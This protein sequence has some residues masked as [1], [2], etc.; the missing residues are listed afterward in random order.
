MI[1]TTFYEKIVELDPA[2]HR[3][4]RFDATHCNFEFS[5]HYTAVPLSCAEFARAA[6]EYPVVF[7]RDKDYL[8]QPVVLLGVKEAENLY[9]NAAGL[10]E[11]TYLPVFVG[12]YPFVME[13][14]ADSSV[15]RIDEKCV[16]LNY[17][18]GELLVDDEGVIQPRLQDEVKF[19]LDYRQA[20]AD[21]RRFIEQLDELFVPACFAGVDGQTVQVDGLYLIDQAKLK[22]IAD[23][24]LPSLFH[25]DALR[26][27]YLHLASLDNVP[28]LLGKAATRA[29]E[30]EF[31][32]SV[33]KKF[34]AQDASNLRKPEPSAPMRRVKPAEEPDSQDQRK[35]EVLRKLAEEKTRLAREHMERYARGAEEAVASAPMADVESSTVAEP[36]AEPAVATV[37]EHAPG[38]GEEARVVPAWRWGLAAVVLLA[39]IWGMS[40]GP[41][42][43]SP[44]ALVV[45][46]KNVP[47]A[48]V[49][50]Q[51]EAISMVHIA[52][53]SFEMGSKRGDSDEKPLQ[54]V[55]VSH[56]FEMGKTEVTQG[57]WR[58]VMGALPE[59]LS[60]K[61]CGEQCP[62]ENVSWND[63]QEFIAR[64]NAKS[65]RHYRLPTEAEWEYACRAGGKHEYCGSDNP[66]S[67]SWYGNAKIGKTPHPVATKEPNAW[68]LYDMSGNVWEWVGDCYQKRYSGAQSQDKP[69]C[70][71]VLRG[72]SWSNDADTPRAAN[73]YKRSAKDRVN[74]NG[75]RLARNL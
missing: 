45:V 25:S 65:G 55:K 28:R 37:V 58:E 41:R 38:P 72:G 8:M 20:L 42:H 50:T 64:L 61:H 32:L 26:L 48:P 15:V 71:R 19:L 16:A 46:E 14:G 74:N 1:N 2:Q 67:V 4:L 51:S 6:H 34:Q 70:E 75:F 69:S 40:H 63:V 7:M 36:D 9:V 57:Q 3:K 29:A 23:D 27:I 60:F 54:R 59:S 56:A 12:H 39:V 18:T 43:A 62:V 66:D 49:V 17:E 22:L 47:P 73:R 10:W 21:T 53:G 30:K 5:R 68:G 31:K 52:Q 13:E 35:Q 24:R 44:P 11:A 33:I